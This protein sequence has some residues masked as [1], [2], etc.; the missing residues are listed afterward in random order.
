MKECPGCAEVELVE[1]IKTSERACW[2]C[3]RIDK[4]WTTPL[5][6][7][8]DKSMYDYYNY[9]PKG[10]AYSDVSLSFIGPQG[11]RVSEYELGSVS[12]K[13]A[14]QMLKR[15]QDQGPMF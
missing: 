3:C 14:K 2:L 8:R 10:W 1:Y 5:I 15:V 9:I 6:S 4:K 13:E 12:L 7:Y 11:Q